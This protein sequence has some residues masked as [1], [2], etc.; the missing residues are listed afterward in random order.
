MLSGLWIGT[1]STKYDKLTLST[2]GEYNQALVGPEYKVNTLNYGVSPLYT[3]GLI[4]PPNSDATS[5]WDDLSYF[6][7]DKWSPFDSWEHFKYELEL[8][9]SNIVYTFN[10]VESFMLVA[11]VIFLIMIWM[12]TSSKI[13]KPSKNILKYIMLTI[14]IYV[15]GYCLIIPEWRYLWFVFIL[16]IVSSFFIVDRLHKNNLISIKI[17][18]IFLIFLLLSF[19]FEPAF[20]I[21]YFANE[22]YPYYDLSNELELNYNIHGNLASNNWDGTST[23][24]YYL[25]SQYY[26]GTKKTNNTTLIDQELIQNNIDYYFVWNNPNEILLKDYHEITNG[27]ISGLRIYKRTN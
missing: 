19:I 9:L 11:V 7:M 18:N 27:T 24:A 25:N 3:V 4:N 26:G 10:L 8:I 23:I 16:L 6:K 15:G 12:M 5:I 14:L 13:D 20:E 17:R 21:S 1:I 2:S 22:K